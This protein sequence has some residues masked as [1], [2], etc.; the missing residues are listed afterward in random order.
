[1]R[2]AANAQHAAAAAVRPSPPPRRSRGLWLNPNHRGQRQ[3]VR[4][5]GLPSFVEP[6]SPGKQRQASPPLPS[7]FGIPDSRRGHGA[8]TAPR[9]PTPTTRP[10]APSYEVVKGA[11][12]EY[13]DVRGALQ[14]P[15]AVLVHGILGSG[16]N[17]R[18][19]AQRLARAFP[20]WQFI[21]V[22]LRCHGAS[23]DVASAS[24][25]EREN[26]VD[27]A[28]R[29]VLGLLKDL[30]LFPNVLIGHSFGGKVILSMVSQFAASTATSA[31]PRPVHAWI[32]DTVPGE[33]RVD[34]ACDVHPGR[35]IDRLRAFPLPLHSPNYLVEQLR[36]EGLSFDIAAWV[37][38]NLRLHSSGRGYDWIFDLEGI[39]EMYASYERTHMWRVIEA[40]PQGLRLDF[41]KAE[42]SSF[43]WAGPDSHRLAKHGVGVHVLKDAGHWVHTDNPQGLVEMMTPSF[44]GQQP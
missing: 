24:G 3:T 16:R 21:L 8:S 28:A 7:H 22:D 13:S 9:P 11:L 40:P 33:V 35:L 17:L 1:M 38:S 41:V 39:S 29:D 32:L 18:S 19:F 42:R 26:S 5:R 31:L 43:R 23:V 6:A 4:V 10:S 20:A 30:Q 14:V 36:S 44:L 12:A 34:P 27:S 37:A 15:T 2:G 25:A